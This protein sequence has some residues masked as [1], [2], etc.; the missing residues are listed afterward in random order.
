MT[1]MKSVNLLERRQK[2][3]MDIQIIIPCHNESKIIEATYKKLIEIL[4]ND[5]IKNK[6]HYNLLFIDDGS[7][8]N[9]LQ[10]LVDFSKMILMLHIYP[11]QEISGKRLLC[12]L[13]LKIA[14]NMMQPS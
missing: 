1:I 4:T 12:M 11:F 5:S 10:Q 7:T 14:L 3:R 8:D 9:T 6:Y 2:N 13:G